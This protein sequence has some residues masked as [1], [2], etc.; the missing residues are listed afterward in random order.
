[1]KINHQ[2][3]T[4]QC[5]DVDIAWYYGCNALKS[6]FSV[7]LD[8]DFEKKPFAFVSSAT[9]AGQIGFCSPRKLLR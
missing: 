6:V 7:K 2:N 4:Y 9:F 1:M 5:F 8:L 3:Q